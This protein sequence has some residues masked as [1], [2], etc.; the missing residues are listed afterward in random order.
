M[1]CYVC[2]NFVD[3]NQP[4]CP[5]C[6]TVLQPQEP[7][8]YEGM[9]PLEV[10]PPMP[11]P[12][13][14]PQPV[15]RKPHIA[16]RI[17]MQLLSFLLSTVL[18]I[19]LIATVLLADMHTLTSS[20][21]IKQ[22]INAVLLPNKAPASLRPMVA[23]GGTVIDPGQIQLPDGAQDAILSGD[24][25]A[26]VDILYDTM[27]EMLGEET[28]ITKEQLHTFV[29]NST[30][31]DFIADKAAGYAEDILSGTENTQITAE[32]LVQLVEENKTVIEETFEIQ[33]TE[34]Q[35]D[36]IKTNVTTIV[37]EN[38]INTTIRTEINNAMD[39]AVSGAAGAGV[40]L[41]EIMQIVRMLSQDTVLYMAIGACVLLLLLLCGTNFYNIP[42]G[43]TW[44]AVPCI[45]VGGILAAPV[46]ILQLTPSILGEF[47]SFAPMINVL[48]VNHYAAP[49]IGLVLLIG[50]IIWRIVRSC[51][52]NSQ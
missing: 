14:A 26:L 5:V 1:Q 15:R 29:E 37:E 6:G 36:E 23:A 43:L 33:I 3:D 30:V 19:V 21:G 12:I 44:A 25:N 49:I 4:Y 22:I 11:E 10:Q 17:G 18:G 2:G 52:R 45:F 42:G 27:Q 35:M 34:E 31:T 41:A 48:A 46:A 7:I 24:S 40:P 13:P 51:I 8:Y 38:D 47:A 28:P 16:L 50:S 32:E 39:S 9:P 20:G